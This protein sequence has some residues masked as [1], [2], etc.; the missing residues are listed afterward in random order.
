MFT[1]Q[2][3]TTL[4]MMRWDEVNLTF[5]TWTI[6]ANK[7][8][9]G[10]ALT[11]FPLF[12]QAVEILTR[13]KSAAAKDAE[14]V[15][16]NVESSTG[17]L[18]NPEKAIERIWKAAK[19]PAFSLHDLRH[20]TATWMNSTGAANR[21]LLPYLPINIATSPA[22]IPRR[23]QTRCVRRLTAAVNAMMQAAGELPLNA[24]TSAA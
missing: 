16:S 5:N 14:W 1:A 9:S 20:T 12:P 15:L 22:S 21:P 17:H 3:R 13:R 11:P 24:A 4:L 8:K 7:M 6:P 19:I 23:R 2:R 10:K 18:R